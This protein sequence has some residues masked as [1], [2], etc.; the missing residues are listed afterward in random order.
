MAVLFCIVMYDVYCCAYHVLLRLPIRSLTYSLTLL[1]SSIPTIRV[2]GYRG[3]NLQD[4][5][6]AHRPQEHLDPHTRLHWAKQVCTGTVPRVGALAFCTVR[7]TLH[8]T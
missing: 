6:Y 1:L 5:A 8:L 2:S 4:H 3:D 7:V